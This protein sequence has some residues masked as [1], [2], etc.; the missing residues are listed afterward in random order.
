[1]ETELLLNVFVRGIPKPQPRP[2]AFA[3]RMGATFVARVYDAGTA[4]SWK[5]A[6]AIALKPFLP[7]IP[8]DGPLSVSIDFFFPRPKC[9]SRKKDPIG[10]IPHAGRPD[11]DNLEKATTDAMTQLG[12]WKDDGQVCAGE[13][14]KF[15]VGMSEWDCTSGARIVVKRMGAAP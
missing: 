3:R 7:P 4:E 12:F 9:L 13:V 8:H 2:R 15:Y 6:V 11:R 14:R 1:M 5:G 10:Y